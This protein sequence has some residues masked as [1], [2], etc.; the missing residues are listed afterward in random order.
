M[1][2]ILLCTLI[3]LVVGCA[4]PKRNYTCFGI[5]EPSAKMVRNGVRSGD[6]LCVRN[7]DIDG[8]YKKGFSPDKRTDFF[9]YILENHK[10]NSGNN[11]TFWPEYFMNSDG[12]A[13]SSD[14]TIHYT[15]S[16]QFDSYERML[17][18]Q[19][20]K[21][22]AAEEDAKIEQEFKETE[23]KYGAKFCTGSRTSNC[24][25]DLPFGRYKFMQHVDKGTLIGFVSW[26]GSP[27]W[28]SPQGYWGKTIY[29]IDGDSDKGLTYNQYVPSGVFKVVGQYSYTSMAGINETV[30]KIKRLSN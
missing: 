12:N 18:E 25:I 24:L 23:A 15:I 11:S 19:E 28:L 26:G 9:N 1:K 4:M 30:V 2:N 8:L 6:S 20:R 7:H 3:I 17:D 29:L 5:N 27:S 21:K 10:F 22:R 16:D 13:I 14:V